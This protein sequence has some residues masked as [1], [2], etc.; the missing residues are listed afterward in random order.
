MSYKPLIVQYICDRCGKEEI[1]INNGDYLSQSFTI[2]HNA[3]K[4]WKWDKKYEHS[5]YE[6]YCA[7][8]SKNEDY[9]EQITNELEEY[10]GFE[11]EGMK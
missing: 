9:H 1:V 11:S 7:V 10:E 2:D 6:H 8:C 3:P 4:H 5:E